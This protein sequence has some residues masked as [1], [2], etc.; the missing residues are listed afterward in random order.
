MRA[1]VVALA[2]IAS[3]LT[4][5][6]CE[7]AAQAAG[8]PDNVALSP[9][10]P[11][12]GVSVVL[13]SARAARGARLRIILY[14]YGPGDDVFERF[15]HVALAVADSTTGENVAFNWGMF[16]FNQP[17]FLGRFLTGDTRYWM[18]GYAT[19]DF[20]ASY[21][22]ENRSIRA[23]ELQLSPMARGAIY[24]YVS[25]NAAEENRFYRYDYYRDN[26][27]TRIRDLLDWAVNGQLGPAWSAVGSSRT[28][29]GET[30]RITATDLPI[31]VLTN[32]ALGRPADRTL[33]RWEE[34][35]LPEHLA[36]HLAS[37][38]VRNATGT[39]VPLVS[40]DTML[41]S[42]GR[43]AMPEAPPGRTPWGLAVGVMLGGTV[44][45]LGRVQARHSSASVALGAMSAVW[46]GAGGVI[47][48]ALLLAGTVTRHDPY[49]GSNLTLM[50]VHPL[51]LLAAVVIPASL[52]RQMPAG[53]T[54]RSTARSTAV[55]IASISVVG[56]IVALFTPLSQQTAVLLAGIVPVHVA[57]A[58]V[59]WPGTPR[60]SRVAPGAVAA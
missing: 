2:S 14:T 53:A 39:L 56:A 50:Q 5:G 54:A 26:C 23:Q 4:W 46:F 19:A 36:T 21:A 34:A 32:I 44:L 38:S 43:E 45:L 27:S 28:W 41:F 30:A 22:G 8:T 10:P 17:N 51:L 6:A 60:G 7:V 40:H 35:F 49:M 13:D 47:G 16:D 59:L 57:F 55:V 18:A 37:T 20:N 58:V 48:T 3:M 25:W 1:G 42:A 24:D 11:A 29:R 9:P 31:Y 33:T 15:G 52:W 12:P